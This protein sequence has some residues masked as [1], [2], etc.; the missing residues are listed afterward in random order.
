MSGRPD[1]VCV[2]HIVREMI[3]F[4]DRTE[5]PVLGSPPAYC[6]VAAARQ[7]TRTG[8][9]TKIG[10]DMPDAL[11]APFSEAG[12]DTAGILMTQRTTASELIYDPSGNKQIRYPAKAEPIRAGDIPKGWRGCGLIYVCTMDNDVMPEDVSD[13]VAMGK[14]SAVDLGGYGGVHMSKSNRDSHPSLERLACEVSTHFDIVKASDEDAIAIF[15]E[16]TPDTSAARLLDCGPDVVVIT[17]G[18][19]GALVYTK[20]GK[21]VVPPLR[22]NAIDT[23]GGGDTFMAGFLSE[24]L[25]SGDPVRSAE[26]GSAT[27]ACVIEKTGG[28]LADR[29]PTYERVLERWH[30]S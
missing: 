22:C 18:S 8:V 28:V 16:D 21:D 17:A 27:A 30:S 15:G 4:P 9:V 1:L 29:M 24:Y 23:T 2:G 13:V 19:K 12:V 26:W 6:S 10:P 5:G 11:L 3:Y 25:R 14:L 7:G 20:Q